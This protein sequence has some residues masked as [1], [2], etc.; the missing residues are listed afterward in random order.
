MDINRLQQ[1]LAQYFDNTVTRKDCEE[2]LRYLDEEAPASVSTAIDE[3]LETGNTL[4]VR[5]N[6]E[7]QDQLYR[8]LMD[9]VN[10]H[11]A[12]DQP[13]IAS[14]K[15]DLTAW[16][17]IAAILIAA[18]SIGLFL[19]FNPSNPDSPPTIA[20]QADDI[21]L[22][23]H[24]QAILTLD[25]GRTIVVS[26]S[27][28][29]ILAQESGV[30]ITKAEDGSILY[31]AAQ[32]DV[33]NGATK[34]HTFS[35]PKG[36]TYRLLLP[37]G[38]KVWLNSSSS[39]QYP[40]VFAR[41][42]RAVSLKGEAYFEVAHD[43]LKPFKV[44]AQG[45]AIEVLGTHFNVSAFEDEAHVTT[46]LLEGVVNVSKNDQRITLKPGEQAIADEKT[47]NIR[48]AQADIRS[49]MAWKNGYFRFDNE[50]IEDIIGKISRWYDIEAVA[51][52]G[53]FNDRFTGTFQ[54]SKNVSQL[55]SHLE[56]LAP[57]HFE[58]KERR[59]VIMK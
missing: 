31:Q 59:V 8:E 37:D 30:N 54:R 55:F 34:Y 47:G 6:R 38:T 45:S 29:G 16:F 33:A 15:S 7:R 35:T 43:A 18:I 11:Q 53:Q 50:S 51:Y 17:R 56:K 23:D 27:I 9:T 49:V 22:P 12:D 20:K 28:V 57:I 32:A 46:T 13:Q 24:N 21:L 4:M 42:E 2:L 19:Y 41:R 39:I 36:H 1:L 40:V 58:I 52:Q 48:Q 14:R 5:F 26:D 10:R 25:D 44:N 3:A